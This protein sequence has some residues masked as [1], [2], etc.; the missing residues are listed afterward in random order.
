MPEIKTFDNPRIVALLKQDHDFSEIYKKF[1]RTATHG[2]VLDAKTYELIQVAISSSPTHL[3][4]DATAY[5]MAEALKDGATKEEIAE[6]LKVVSILGVHTCAVGVPIVMKH[7]PQAKTPLTPAQQQLKERFIETMG[8]WN[9]FRDDLLRFDT[10]YFEQYFE[11][12]TLPMR[13]GILTPKLIEFIYIAID[14]STTHLFDKGIDVHIQGAIEKG[15]TKEEIMAV[16]QITAGQG[17]HTLLE[18]LP[19]LDNVVENLE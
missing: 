10:A 5:H 18:M 3:S 8:Y 6:V 2:E 9:D 13:R 1:S 7:L 17:F 12:L 4:K 16:I 14:A 15:A 11:F 19:L